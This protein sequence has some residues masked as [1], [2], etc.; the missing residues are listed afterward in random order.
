MPMKS[1]LFFSGALL[2]WTWQSA[3]ALG[4]ARARLVLR[5]SPK[6][7]DAGVKWWSP[8]DIPE[9]DIRKPVVL[10]DV[11]GVLNGVYEELISGIWSDSECL[12]V[13]SPN[14]FQKT[15]RIVFSRTV[16]ETINDWS[17]A[18]R[19]TVVWLT[20]WRTDAVTHLAPALGIDDFAVADWWPKR[21]TRDQS[22]SAET[23]VLWIDDDS[24]DKEWITRRPGTLGISP[25]ILGGGLTPKLLDVAD[26]F[27][28]GQFVNTD[29]GH[30]Y[31]DLGDGKSR[32][33]G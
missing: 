7:E 6:G 16:V 9:E 19:C 24:L 11:D 23:P 27:L 28:Q 25:S 33:L 21:K 8:S 32:F 31:A 3:L 1:V 30:V 10:L 18:D 13:Y 29:R 17:R 12:E 5:A 26:V 20:T 2:A 14:N 22:W 4:G 15:Y